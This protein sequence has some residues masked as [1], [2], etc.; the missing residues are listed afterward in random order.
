[1]R[2]LSFSTDNRFTDLQIFP[3]EVTHKVLSKF[4]KIILGTIM[5][6]KI[7]TNM[8]NTDI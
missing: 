5:S 7:H 1:M 2:H 8:E 3:Y 4:H 6:K